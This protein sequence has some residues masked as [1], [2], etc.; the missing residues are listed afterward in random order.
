MVSVIIPVYNAEAFLPSAVESVLSQTMTDWEIILVD[1]GSTDSSPLICDSLASSSARIHTIHKTNGGLSSARNAALDIA[2]GD[3]ITFLDAD[4]LLH[5]RALHLL[6]DAAIDADAEISS[7][8]NLP[9]S[10][11]EAI[12]AASVGAKPEPRV[13][14]AAQAIRNIL[15]Q[16]E[17]DNSACGKLYAARIWRDIRFRE[18]TGYEDLDIICPVVAKA[19]R[20]AHIPAELYLYRQHP[21]SYVHTL[22]LRRA[23]VLHV[24]R[25]LTAYIA[26]NFPE[27]LPA[28]HSRQ[29]SAN[30]NILGLIAANRHRLP[31]QDIPKAMLLE[32]ECWN[33]IKG[34]RGQSLRNPSVRLKNKMGIIASYIGGAPLLRWLSRVIYSS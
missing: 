18:G 17:P 3:Y 10:R 12:E 1:D 24:C 15:Y 32:K 4:D 23:D 20:V 21:A 16:R 33:T 34:L 2:K 7:C 6:L 19:N 13:M 27:L 31:E 26:D 8:R 22:S 11:P 9:F 30:F 28:A 29:I 5:P 25:R 14:T